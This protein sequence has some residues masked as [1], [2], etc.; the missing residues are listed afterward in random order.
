MFKKFLSY[1]LGLHW[2]AKVALAASLILGGFLMYKFVL[3]LFPVFF[4]ISALIF[5]STDGEIFTI[6]W[7]RYKQSQ[8]GYEANPSLE[9]NFYNWLTE[10]GVTE[11]PISSIQFLQGV[12]RHPKDGIY[13]IHLNEEI[14]TDGLDTF[15]MK[16]RQQMKLLSFGHYDCVI[17]LV[18]KE[19]FLAIKVRIVKSS[20]VELQNTVKKEDF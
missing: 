20:D 18:K 8:L 11:L 6:L 3:L 12:E 10:Q 4:V 16:A 1:L 17:A 14:P 7:Q 13:Y 5:I 9:E 15:A 19:P 2:G